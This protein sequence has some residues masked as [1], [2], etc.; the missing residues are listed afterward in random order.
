[1]YLLDTQTLLHTGRLLSPISDHHRRKRAKPG[2]FP[3]HSRH[4]RLPAGASYHPNALD[5]ES[6][7]L[8]PMTLVLTCRIVRHLI[9]TKILSS[10]EDIRL[11]THARF[12][13]MTS[14]LMGERSVARADSAIC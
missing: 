7:S 6:E 12:R 1:M 10:S 11:V 14:F 5:I 13:C 2:P 9:A 8:I 3:L 4:Q